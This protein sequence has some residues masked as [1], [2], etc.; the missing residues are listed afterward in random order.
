MVKTSL[1]K[2]KDKIKSRAYRKRNRKIVNQKARDKTKKRKI[3]VITHYGK[4]CICCGDI[5]IEFLS[6]NHPNG[7]GAKHRR[8][9]GQGYLYLWLIKNNFPDGFEVMCMNC[10]WGS[11][12]TGICPH[13]VS[14]K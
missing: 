10:N 6:I 2:E 5:H 14:T 3:L 8:K 9:I 12:N 11:R 1:Q 7:D 13:K 4:K